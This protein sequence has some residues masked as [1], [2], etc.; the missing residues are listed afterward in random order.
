MITYT[1]LTPRALEIV[2]EGHVTGADAREAFGRMERLIE[3]APR[4]D[5]LADVREG[6][7]IEFG[8]ILE[9]LRHLPMFRRMIGALDRIAL[10]ADPAWVRA[11][12]RIE[13]HLIPGVDYRVFD[14][15]GAAAARAWILREGE[16]R[17]SG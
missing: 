12:G 1:S 7:H 15:D 4:I 13:S 14:R 11:V 6:I 10:V 8:A 9:E 16:G 3:T 17:A 2:C 5:I